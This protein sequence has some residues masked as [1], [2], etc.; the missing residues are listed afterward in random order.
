MGKWM[1]A[2]IHHFITLAVKN[3]SFIKNV[4]YRKGL[5]DYLVIPRARSVVVG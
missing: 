3:T 2:C 4:V 1:L 5:V